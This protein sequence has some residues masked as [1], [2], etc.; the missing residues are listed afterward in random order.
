[1]SKDSGKTN[2]KSKCEIF[3]NRIFLNSFSFT[4]I[5]QIRF[6]L[7]FQGQDF[8]TINLLNILEV[9]NPAIESAIESTC[10]KSKTIS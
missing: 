8:L 7:K 6:D 2:N 10:T 3:G 4:T 9:F 5:F 1:M